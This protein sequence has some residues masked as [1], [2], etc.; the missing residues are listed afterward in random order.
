MDTTTEF[1]RKC[2]SNKSLYDTLIKECTHIYNL[3]KVT[4]KIPQKDTS[5]LIKIFFFK[6]TDDGDSHI[7]QY[8]EPTSIIIEL[9]NDSGKV[10]LMQEYNYKPDNGYVDR[11]FKIKVETLDELQKKF[12]SSSFIISYTEYCES[13][14][15][16]N[17]ILGKIILK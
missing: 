12:N 6:D 1:Y 10:L 4:F 14:I 16:G 3:D 8:N 13:C 15:T 9:H 7:I 11:D 17:I 2:K 5:G